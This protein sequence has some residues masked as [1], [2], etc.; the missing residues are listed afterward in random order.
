[1]PIHS[2]SRLA[3]PFDTLRPLTRTAGASGPKT[4]L[5]STIFSGAASEAAMTDY[6]DTAP[7]QPQPAEAATEVGAEDHPRKGAR[8]GLLLILL[9]WPV[10]FVIG[11]ALVAIFG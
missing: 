10:V 2:V 5:P 4:G 6:P 1:M 7:V 8:W 9:G 3:Q 11:G